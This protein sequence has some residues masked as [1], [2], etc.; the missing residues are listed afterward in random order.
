MAAL[1]VEETVQVARI[2]SEK[3]LERLRNVAMGT[4]RVKDTL[5]HADTLA[6]A[7]QLI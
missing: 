4:N 7:G 3:A 2:G 1:I 5:L 6:S